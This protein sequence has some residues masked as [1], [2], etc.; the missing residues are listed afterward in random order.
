MPKFGMRVCVIFISGSNSNST[1]GSVCTVTGSCV[2]A[3]E[4]DKAIL[5]F[6]TFYKLFYEW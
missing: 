1:G 5:Q 6:F 4:K 2:A 3:E